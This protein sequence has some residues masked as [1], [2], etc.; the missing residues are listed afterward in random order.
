[1]TMSQ[2]ING[3]PHDRYALILYGSETGN[4]HD[5][6]GRLGQITER[7]HFKTIVTE[8]DDF[9]EVVEKKMKSGEVVSHLSIPINTPGMQAHENDRRKSQHSKS[10]SCARRH[11]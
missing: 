3:Q 9:A 11:Y 5:V 2:T 7:L 10:T 4:S 6:A 8:M 1:M